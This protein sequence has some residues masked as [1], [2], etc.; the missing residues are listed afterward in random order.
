MVKKSPKHSLTYLFNM[1]TN[2]RA[3]IKTTGFGAIGFGVLSS[4]DL[5]GKDIITSLPRKSPESQGVDSA[6]I[7]N[8]LKA[9][10]ESGLEW[11]S[12]MLVRHGNVVA[13]GCERARKLARE[14]MREV[15]DAMGLGYSA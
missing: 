4:T 6:G 9:T 13:E 10:K 14:T 15:R 1:K 5:F 2:R 7:R 8:F 11:H 3:F 12:I